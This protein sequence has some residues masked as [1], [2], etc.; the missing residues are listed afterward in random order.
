MSR[1]P[2]INVAAF[3]VLVVIL[4]CGGDTGITGPTGTVSGKVT[5]KGA[6]L[7]AGCSIIF[8]GTTKTAGVAIG[9]VTTDG[10]YE[11]REAGGAKVHVGSYLVTL[12]P[13]PT[14]G[15]DEKELADLMSKPVNNDEPVV[16]TP[17]PAGPFPAKYLSSETSGLKFDVKEGANPIDITLTE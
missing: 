9:T 16:E 15:L 6:P 1:T 17:P 7:P 4:G 8:T 3:T 12:T 14:K 11:L 13:P 10:K 2:W 5:F